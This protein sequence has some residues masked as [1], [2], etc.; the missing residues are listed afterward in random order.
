MRHEAVATA[1]SR[2]RA[3][4]HESTDAA[5][6]AL[7][8]RRVSERGIA[9]SL[10]SFCPRL[11]YRRCVCKKCLREEIKLTACYSSVLSVFLCLAFVFCRL[12]LTAAAAAAKGCVTSGDWRSVFTMIINLTLSPSHPDSRLAVSLTQGRTTSRGCV[13]EREATDLRHQSHEEIREKGDVACSERER[14]RLAT[15]KTSH[16]SRD[17]QRHSPITWRLSWLS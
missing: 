15:R 16:T 3:P 14:R 4:D 7:T 1:N 17:R 12:S 2:K 13:G 9:P 10:A 5:D 11:Q 8:L 6:F